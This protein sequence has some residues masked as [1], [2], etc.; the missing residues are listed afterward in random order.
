MCETFP[1]EVRVTAVSVGYGLAYALF[2]GT[3][4]AVAVW[5]IDKTG[6]DIAFGWYIVAVTVISLGIA[7]TLRDRRNEPLED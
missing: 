6:N 5:L 4:P 2:G 3:A 7:F 1:H